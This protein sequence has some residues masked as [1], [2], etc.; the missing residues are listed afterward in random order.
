MSK[1]TI[2]TKSSNRFRRLAIILAIVVIILVAGL[3]ALLQLYH[4]NLSAVSGNQDARI[5]TIEAG[6]GVRQI[7][8]QL[9]RQ[10]LIR[11]AWTLE[12]YAHSQNIGAKF[13]AGSYALAPSSSTQQIVS[14]LTKGRVATQLVTILPGR[15][16]DQVRAD[17]INDGF[18]PG[19]VDKALQPAQYANLPLLAL[20]PAESATLE[21]L[22]WP[23]SFQKD[24]LTDPSFIIRESLDEMA[25]HL[26]PDLKAAFS[27]ENLS[28]YQGITLASIIEQEVSKP[29]DRAQ[30]AQVFLSRLKGGMMLGSDVTARY[31]SIVAN[32]APSLSYD[33]AYNTHIHTGLPPS[34][35][36]SISNGSLQAASHPAAT[37]W[38][39]FVTGDDGTTYFSKTLAEH[40]AYTEK[41]CHNLCGR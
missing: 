38:V 37:A 4:R 8:A 33:S 21:G 3:V 7:A 29:S 12:L 40:Q 15:R 25:L 39:Y 6:S 17:L 19:A 1:Y 14:I 30:A 22:L 28:L 35:I 9:E 36:S 2:Q 20:K 13:Q 10:H 5:I 23:D 41:Y 32:K 26:T 31:G 24:A 27:A 34:P 16:I 11:S 18:S